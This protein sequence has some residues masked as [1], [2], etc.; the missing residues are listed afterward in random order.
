[1][2]LALGPVAR[3]RTRGLYALLQT[4]YLWCDGLQPNPEGEVELKFWAESFVSYNAQPIWRS[5]GAAMT[6]F[7]I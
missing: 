1:M 6:C 7:Q 3:L 4:R 2:N 5:P